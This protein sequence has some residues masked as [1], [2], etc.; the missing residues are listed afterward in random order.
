MLYLLNYFSVLAPKPLCGAQK[1]TNWISPVWNSLNAAAFLWLHR[2]RRDVKKL[3]SFVCCECMCI[4]LQHPHSTHALSLQPLLY[5]FIV[6]MC[7]RVRACVCYRWRK[8]RRWKVLGWPC[9]LQALLDILWSWLP[10]EIAFPSSPPSLYLTA[11]VDSTNSKRSG[12]RESGLD[13]TSRLCEPPAEFQP[14][15]FMCA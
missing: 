7:V 4:H 9:L 3:L 10:N 1:N 8:C 13:V 12:E 6:S 2:K 11:R 5:R 15:A 14:P